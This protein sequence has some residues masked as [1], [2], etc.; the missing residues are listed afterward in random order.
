[1][2]AKMIQIAG[3]ANMDENSNL[4]ELADAARLEPGDA[5][6]AWRLLAASI[7]GSDLPE[8][9]KEHFQRSAREIEAFDPQTGD[10]A[11][12]AHDLGF[13]KEIEVRPGGNYDLD[14]VFDWFTDRM[15]KDVEEGKKINI[16]RTAREYLEENRMPNS[17]PGGLRK[18]YETVRERHAHR[19]ETGMRLERLLAERGV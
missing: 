11:K 13:Y 4:D 7:E 19:M 10:Q 14:H 2:N 15:M 9:A 1:M 16:S 6:K 17:A 5:K 8:W 3:A 18:A 12:L